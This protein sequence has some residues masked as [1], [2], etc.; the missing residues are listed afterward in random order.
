M[1][2]IAL[3]FIFLVLIFLPKQGASQDNTTLNV[4]NKRSEA[5]YYFSKGDQAVNVALGFSNTSAF[6]F[7]LFQ[8]SGSGSPSPALDVT[9]EYGL[10][11]NVSIGGFVSYYRVDA[12]ADISYQDV[13]DQLSNIDI[14]DFGS[15]VSSIGCILDPSSCTTS[16]KERTNVYTI[17]GKLRYSRLFVPKLETYG[18]TY[19]GYSFNRRK[20]I[21]EQALNTAV[22]EL[23]LSTDVPT[24]VY[25]GSFGARYFATDN[26]GIWG[27]YGLGNVHLFKMGVSYRW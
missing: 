6:S 18:A 20:T 14:N 12:S 24:F 26:I 10:F 5:S 15:I 16:I 8:A 13:A 3:T 22:S 23:G 1:N 7:N 2:N 27:E 11:D 19:L 21:T 17:G 25:F 4:D 9:Y